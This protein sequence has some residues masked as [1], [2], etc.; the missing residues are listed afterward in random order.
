M[1]SKVLRVTAALTV[2]ACLAALTACTTTGAATSNTAASSAPLKMGMVVPLTGGLAALGQGSKDAAELMV[3]QLNAAGGVNGQDIE[4]T[5][6]DDKTDVTEGV[7]QFNQL[8][9][10]PS[11]SAMLGS[12]YTQAATAEGATAESAKIPMIALSPV[13][14]FVDGSNPYAFTGPAT[15]DVYAKALVDYWKS[16][17]ITTVAI[18]FS[19]D[20]F[21]QDGSDATKKYAEEAGIEV[22]LDESH[23]VFATDFTPLVTK[24]VAAKPEAFALWSAGPP[25][26]IITAQ[27]E[28]KGIPIYGT[29]AIASSLFIGPA[30]TAAEGVLAATTAS[31][32]TTSLPAGDYRDQVVAL[33]DAWMTAHEGDPAPEFAYG[34]AA[35]VQLLAE[36]ARKAGSTDRESLRNALASLEV[37]T[38]AGEYSFADDRHMGLTEENLAIMTVENGAWVPTQYSLDLFAAAK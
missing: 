20:L 5:I 6:V 23:D 11:Y 25:A 14:A 2:T 37:V 18:G 16:E 3:A 22:V 15:P 19:A 28:G 9:A 24:V 8:A 12:S 31:M 29:G 30:G 32:A 34:G 38:V 27:L 17:D 36:A 10:D 13:S 33:N 21:G 35:A 26:V 4:L 1:S 7:K